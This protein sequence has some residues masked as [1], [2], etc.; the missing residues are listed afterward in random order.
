MN[1]TI[2]TIRELWKG[3]VMTTFPEAG[4][5]RII[6]PQ[7]GSSRPDPNLLLTDWTCWWRRMEGEAECTRSLERKDSQAE[8]ESFFKNRV[9]PNI[10][11]TGWTTWWSRTEAERRKE[12][13]SVMN[14]I[15]WSKSRAYTNN[16]KK[17][18]YI[19]KTFHM[20]SSTSRPSAPRCQFEKCA[21]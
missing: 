18:N 10:I 21:A 4:K 17:D 9:Q 14:N 16:I 5:P 1:E 6:F 15:D 12:E 13:K 11:L 3:E 8:K 19:R 7:A 2:E 20:P